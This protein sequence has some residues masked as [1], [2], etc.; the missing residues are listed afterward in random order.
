MKHSTVKTGLAPSPASRTRILWV[1]ETRQAAPLRNKWSGQFRSARVFSHFF[2]Q[3]DRFGNF[4]HGLALLPALL[5]Q[6]KVS[7]LFAQ[8]ELALQ[9]QFGAFHHFSGL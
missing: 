3:N 1:I 8:S 6:S 5:L 4:P 7:L 9:N 2:A